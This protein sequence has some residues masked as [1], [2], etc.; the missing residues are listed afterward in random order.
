MKIGVISDI[1][2][3]PLSLELAWS[4]LTVMGA[5]RIVCAGDVVGYGPFPDRTVKFLDARKIEAVRGNHDR[6]AIARGPGL[7]DE[8][9]GGA[10]SAKAI[11]VIAALPPHL[12]IETK[13]RIV[14]VVHGSPASDMEYVRRNSHGP[15]VLDNLLEQLGADILVVGHTHAPMWYRGERG[16]VVNPGSAISMPVVRTSRTFAMLDTDAMSVTFHDV[17]TG[18]VLDVPHWS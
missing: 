3:D 2:S 9:G 18:R 4:H 10:P 16:L 13:G 7:R 6:W 17:E 8:F 15:E 1:H 5:E 11:A 12:V 14:V